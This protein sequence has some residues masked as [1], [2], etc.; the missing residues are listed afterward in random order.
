MTHRF[1]D[2]ER[3][4]ARCRVFLSV[5]AIF[6]VY[7]D[8]TAPTLAW[9][10]PE[11]GGAFTI[12]PSALAVMASHLA[13]STTLYVA[14]AYPLGSPRRLAA[15][16]TWADVLFGAAIALFT[17]G[18]TSPFYAFFIFAVLAVG[19]RSG[20]RQT[21]IVT[22]A[23]V[24]LYLS[25]II[26][27][28]H[29]MV[30]FY[31]MRPAYLAITGYLVGYLGQQRLNLEARIRELET[32]EQRQVIARSLH[33]GYCQSLAGVN[34]RLETCRELL[35]RGRIEDAFAEL[36][37][38]QTG[39]NREY[40]GLRTYIRSLADVDARPGALVESNDTRFA[41]R[42]D[43]AGPLPLVEH[44]LQ[45]LLEGAR[46]VARHARAR[47]AGLDV[48]SEDDKLLISIQDDGVGFPKDA[49]APWSI[50][51]RVAEVGGRVRVD[52]RNGRGAH[53]QVELPG[54]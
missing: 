52:R 7:V 32:A 9:W 4:I 46:N 1:I 44:A 40:D 34:L 24:A 2:I 45:I 3:N 36:T 41:V 15:I 26:V 30:N 19:F 31:L 12:D 23:S 28:S 20:L 38:L 48:R 8:P 29:D 22:A 53:L 37:D 42:T 51:S 17:E 25:L 54:A 18:T 6:A 16:A 35:R 27:S 43:C 33:D 5:I 49:E 39:V 14:L 50:A 21:L 11:K 10:I 47:A 13:Y